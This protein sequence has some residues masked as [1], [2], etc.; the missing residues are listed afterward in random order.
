MNYPFGRSR[1]AWKDIVGDFR[2]RGPLR[3]HEHV[4][5]NLTEAARSASP[6]RRVYTVVQRVLFGF[7]AGISPSC[8]SMDGDALAALL[9]DWKRGAWSEPIAV[10]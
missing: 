1:F 8:S 3:P 6:K 9:N 4:A 2:D 10:C 7:D 5:F